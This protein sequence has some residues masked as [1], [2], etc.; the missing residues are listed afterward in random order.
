MD[1]K[2]RRFDYKRLWRELQLRMQ[3]RIMI[4]RYGHAA[5]VRSIRQ[6]LTEEELQ[7]GREDEV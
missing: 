1:E 5:T 4:M 7:S 6:V 3:L 2:K